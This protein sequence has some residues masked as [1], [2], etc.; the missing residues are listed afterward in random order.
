MLFHV[1]QHSESVTVLENG[2]V[3]YLYFT[4]QLCGVAMISL[5]VL[6]SALRIK[7]TK[8][9]FRH[10]Q[11]L[12]VERGNPLFPP[13]FLWPSFSN[14]REILPSLLEELSKLDQLAKTSKLNRLCVTCYLTLVV[15]VN[16]RVRSY[17]F[18]L[19]RIDWVKYELNRPA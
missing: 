13:Y 1:E 16:C 9:Q 8:N 5:H 11:E 2:V 14:V 6:P 19:Y 3:D 10:S 4:L 15:L 18:M 17:F 7:R 12:Q